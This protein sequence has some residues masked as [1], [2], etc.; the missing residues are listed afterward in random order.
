M[1]SYGVG[2]SRLVGA[3]I[4]AC[5]DEAGIVWPDSVAPWD[6]GVLN[7]KPGDAAT[8]AIVERVEAQL[9]AAGRTVL[10]DDTDRGRARSSRR[11]TSSAC[12]GR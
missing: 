3:I 11:W 8:D 2:V 10:T 4:E 7:L 6:V 9:E 1:G 5:H 12:P